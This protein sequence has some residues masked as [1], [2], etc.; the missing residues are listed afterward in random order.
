MVKLHIS[1][2]RIYVFIGLIALTV[3]IYGLINIRLF[4]NTLTDLILNE[5]A[6][7]LSTSLRNTQLASS[8]LSAS[9]A[10]IRPDSEEAV[11]MM[12]GTAQSSG[13]SGI[14]VLQ[15]NGD[16]LVCFAAQGVLLRR[17]ATGTVVRHQK[18][19]MLAL[20]EES[21]RSFTASGE[22]LLAALGRK[23]V[24]PFTM[25]R[26]S[27]GPLL[28]LTLS[29]E[30][31]PEV[32]L[33]F[34]PRQLLSHLSASVAMVNFGITLTVE[35][36]LYAMWTDEGMSQHYVTGRAANLDTL[37]GDGNAQTRL[38]T[39]DVPGFGT[40]SLK[41][42][43][44][45]ERR[46][47]F[48][49]LTNDKRFIYT[50]VGFL[51]VVVGITLFFIINT[52]NRRRPYRPNVL[53]DEAYVRHR[54]K[55]GESGLTEFKS[56]LRRNLKSGKNDKNIELA[57]LKAVASFLN[58][59][60][61]TLLVGVGDEGEIL[62]LGPDE[63]ENDDHALRHFSNLVTQHLGIR[64]FN[65]I[66]FH[67]VHVGDKLVLA[68]ICRKSTEPVFLRH[69]NEEWFLVRQGPSNKS[70]CLSEFYA[71]ARKFRH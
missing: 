52:V 57:S 2:T 58:T 46:D 62:G 30:S 44:H 15:E 43:V 69:R 36:R 21:T 60:G 29:E 8:D 18:S 23:D 65:E 3:I 33:F 1:A 41:L 40:D 56:T 67:A 71:V 5:S 47:L 42:H 27:T 38:F 55:E 34:T 19:A 20:N 28:L 53:V 45:T 61:G 13:A 22:A 50:G 54:A 51:A 35:D 17:T 6:T 7:E 64:H 63:F 37:I 26:T 11:G 39:A 49:N 12:Q 14:V 31:G 4:N 9:L 24:P 59:D 48:S 66:A 70:L 10:D 25:V 32:Y 68:V 16:A